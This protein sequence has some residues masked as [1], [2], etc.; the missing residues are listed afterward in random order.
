MDEIESAQVYTTVDIP[1]HS[2]TLLEKLVKAAKK[3]QRLSDVDGYSPGVVDLEETLDDDFQ[4]KLLHL[5]AWTG[6]TPTIEYLSAIADVDVNVATA[7]GFTPLHLAA[8]RGH[9][10]VLRNLLRWVN[11]DVLAVSREGFTALHL[12]AFGGHYQ[13]AEALLQNCPTNNHVNAKDEVLGRTALHWAVA[14]PSSRRLFDL[15]TE[16][17]HECQ[18]DICAKDRSGFTPLHFATMSVTERILTYEQKR[19]LLRRIKDPDFLQDENTEEWINDFFQDESKKQLLR[20]YRSMKYSDGSLEQAILS[21]HGLEDL[22]RRMVNELLAK[23]PDQVSAKVGNVRWFLSRKEVEEFPSQPWRELS[24]IRTIYPGLTGVRVMDSSSVPTIHESMSGYSA[25][26][27]AACQNNAELVSH[28]LG[29]PNVMVNDTDMIY[30]MTPLHCSLWAG[31]MR[32]FSRLMLFEG[33]DVNVGLVRGGKGPRQSVLSGEFLA[34][35]SDEGLD[36]DNLLAPSPRC[37]LWPRSMKRNYSRLIITPGVEGTAQRKEDSAQVEAHSEEVI[38]QVFPEQKKVPNHLTEFQSSETPLHIGIRYCPPESLQQ[39]MITFCKHPRLDPAIVNSVGLQPLQLAWARS[40]FTLLNQDSFPKRFEISRELKTLKS[41]ILK[42]QRIAED[43]TLAPHEK[44]FTELQPAIALLEAHPGNRLLMHNMKDEERR[45]QNVTN[46]VVVAATVIAGFTFQG[47]L[48]P[49]VLTNLKEST[50]IRL[51]QATFWISNSTAFFVA[52]ALL[53]ACLESF[54]ARPAPNYHR[55]YLDSHMYFAYQQR[56]TTILLGWSIISGLIA[57]Y[58]ASIISFRDKIS[59]SGAYVY[60]GVYS[61]WFVYTVALCYATHYLSV[62]LK[63]FPKYIRR[64]VMQK[65][66]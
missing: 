27:F 16:N 8:S 26:H 33:L 1:N 43:A 65:F 44:A 29:F 18:A 15:L 38:S 22:P 30:G 53:L 47:I 54:A 24:G 9:T 11:A 40:V 42:L 20:D 14:H 19:T 49:P 32:A 52:V 51:V 64:D 2:S 45:F 46:V 48:Q 60:L 58:F 66:R 37:S 50:H 7:G 41:T 35:E 28:L 13:C 3:N 62:V 4:L 17:R 6:D 25:L 57:Y 39:M 31:A 56:G 34:G 23:R 36:D 21:Q 10:E 5:A 55:L 59:F 61:I 63:L 12:A